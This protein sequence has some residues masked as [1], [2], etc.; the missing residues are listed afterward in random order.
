MVCRRI[1]WLLCLVFVAC[2]AAAAQ[3][4]AER[5]TPTSAALQLTSDVDK[6]SYDYERTVQYLASGYLARGD[7]DAALAAVSKVEHRK[8]SEQLYIV[9]AAAARA[10]RNDQAQIALNLALKLVLSDD[11]DSRDSYWIS[12]F[13]SQAVEV[14]E[15]KLAARFINLLND[16]SEGKLRTLVELAQCQQRR[17]DSDLAR[18]TLGNAITELDSLRTADLDEYFSWL[19]RI[20]KLLVRLGNQEEADRLLKDAELTSVPEKYRTLA[21]SYLAA[22]YANVGA[23]ERASV[24]VESLGGGS[25]SEYIAL[26][27][28]YRDKGDDV[29]ALSCMNRALEIA[30]ADD[31]SYDALRPIVT[32][33]LQL[34]RPDDALPLLRRINNAYTIVESAIEVAT[35]YHDGKRD[36]DATAALGLA[37]S[38]V[39]KIVSEKSEDIPGYASTSK[40]K[41]KSQALACLVR[42]YLKLGDFADAEAAASEV[43]QPQFR[44]SALSE[45]AAAYHK[46]GDQGRARSLLSAAFNLS[47]GAAD[48]NHDTWRTDTLLQI[49][50]AYVDA[51]LVQEARGVA[52]RFLTELE[53]QDTN[54]ELIWNLMELGRVCDKGNLQLGK[55]AQLKL[56]HLVKEYRENT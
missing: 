56:A 49:A 13:A 4:K 54:H 5:L 40:A 2:G 42:E 29:A 21:D 11:E 38:R 53:R 23:L 50:E 46:N 48:Y 22:S 26:A 9:V 31:A 6:T 16:R 24:L 36:Q 30:S 39:R 25:S 18:A 45:V 47:S 20:T 52:Q 15:P 10:G 51:G 17:G 7:Y 27:L 8:Q 12:G 33:Y 41:E 28:A 14:G 34:G 3:R 35:A 1:I 37:L 32:G 44:A 43:D 55:S 19:P